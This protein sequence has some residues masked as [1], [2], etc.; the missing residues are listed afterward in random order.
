MTT[1]TYPHDRFLAATLLKLVPREATPNQITILRI[2]MTPAVVWFLH[3][4]RYDLAVAFFLITALTDM[5]D[6]SLARTRGQ[7]TAW[8]TMW[9]PIADKLLI[10]SVALLLLTRHFPPELTAVI[11]G[12]EA[13][14]LAGGWYRTTQGESVA[15]NWWGKFKMLAQ[16]IGVTLFLLSLQTGLAGLALA[17]YAAFGVACVLAL[18]SLFRHGL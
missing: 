5:L 3:E 16:V 2:F 11:L 8:G 17:S 7:V 9:D 15:A 1:K 6:G 14:F 10:G 4:E 13:A 12:L 18:V